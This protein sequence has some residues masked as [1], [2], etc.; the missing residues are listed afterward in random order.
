[1]R[2]FWARPWLSWVE[3]RRECGP[4][5]Q[6]WSLLYVQEQE[7][8]QGRRSGEGAKTQRTARESQRQRSCHRARKSA[9]LHER[10]GGGGRGRGKEEA[11]CGAGDRAREEVQLLCPLLP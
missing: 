6:I 11:P 9:G 5:R 4:E 2:L 8:A 7:R 3:S 1:M 10:L